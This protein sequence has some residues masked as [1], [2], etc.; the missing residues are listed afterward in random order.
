MTQPQQWIGVGRTETGHVRTSNQDALALL[1]DCGVW[2]VADGMG[3]HP[4]GD[5]AAQTAVAVA[6]QRARER[7]AWLS[8]HPSAAS[9]FVADLVTSANQRIHDVMLAKPSL[10]GMGTTLVALAIMSAPRPIAHIAHL[11]DSRAYLYRTGQLKQLT[12]DHTLVEKFVQRGLIDAATALTHPERHILTK[13]LGMGVDMKPELTSTSVTPD[14]LILLCSDG[15][16]K[17]LEDAAI[18][19][20]LSRAN[21]D[22]HRGCHALIEQALNR[23]GEDNV[24]VIVVAYPH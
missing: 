18:A 6:T 24:T 22:P 10:K 5:I 17:M 14:D 21:G 3:G 19:S 16:T 12:R 15:L 9:E 2:I 1:N 11:G 7:A 20:V 13:G 8:E 4:A 23:G